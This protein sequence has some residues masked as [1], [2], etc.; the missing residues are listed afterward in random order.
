MKSLKDTLDLILPK[1]EEAGKVALDFKDGLE[2]ILDNSIIKGDSIVHWEGCNLLKLEIEE[3]V[4]FA[5]AIRYV[6]TFTSELLKIISNPSNARYLIDDV[7]SPLTGVS[8][9]L[10]STWNKWRKIRE[11]MNYSDANITLPEDFSEDIKMMEEFEVGADIDTK[12]SILEFIRPNHSFY[13]RNKFFINLDKLDCLDLYKGWKNGSIL[14]EKE[15]DPLKFKGK[16][17]S[18][19]QELKSIFLWR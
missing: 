2:N 1:L 17:P 8:F 4:Y 10:A 9:G 16:E 12:D 3:V 5:R 7:K 19:W 11:S 15:D 6:D 14:V 18:L 13:Y